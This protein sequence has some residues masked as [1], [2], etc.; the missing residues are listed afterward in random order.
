M[1]TRILIALIAFSALATAEEAVDSL[2]ALPDSA[3]IQHPDGSLSTLEPGDMPFGPGERMEFIVSFGYLDIGQATLEVHEP[4]EIRG[5]PV[6]EITNSARSASWV[7]R[8][9]KIRDKIVSFMDLEQR[10]SLGFH[11]EIREG[12]YERDMHAEYLQ[13]EGLARYEKDGDVELVPGSH[14]IMTALYLLRTVDLEPGM[15]LGIPL[16]DDKK[17]YHVEVKVLKRETVETELGDMDCLLLEPVLQSG[18]IFNKAGRLWV[19]VSEDERRL[20]VQ[21][22]SKAP[23]GAFT[24][25]I[26]EYQPPR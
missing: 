13:D 24:S 20:I 14:D 12:R 1:T 26:Y 25:R 8:V 23:V 2:H 3:W 11:K 22:K 19:W 21:L 4:R 9:F 15:R 5:R 7:D 17:N 10:F 16:H 18:G 6:L